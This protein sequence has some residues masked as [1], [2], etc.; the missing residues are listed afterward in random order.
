MTA[1]LADLRRAKEYSDAGNYGAKAELMRRLIFAA[2]QDFAVDSVRN[3]VAGVTHTPTVFRVHLPLTAVPAQ[4][5]PSLADGKAPPVPPREKAAAL[6]P[7]AL[8][9]ALGGLLGA[10]LGYG[11]G[12]LAENLAP[13]GVLQKGKLRRNLAMMGGGLGALPGA[14]LGTISARHLAEQGH[15]S[16]W[17][18]GFLGRDRLLGPDATTAAMPQTESAPKLAGLRHQLREA[19]AVGRSDREPLTDKAASYFD[20]FIPADQFAAAAWEDPLS[21]LPLKLYQTAVVSTAA[22]QRLSPFVSP[23]D[24]ARVAIGMGSGLAAGALLGKV[25]GTLAGLTPEAQKAVQQAG[26]WYGAVRGALS[27]GG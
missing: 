15:P 9:S 23:M 3:G 21:P 13:E 8:T 2:P 7:A 16:P 14:W 5:R 20:A 11:A 25:V 4:I 1:P 17:T 12:A 26:L 18:E 10:G 27:T 19:F 22:Q 24:V 6:P